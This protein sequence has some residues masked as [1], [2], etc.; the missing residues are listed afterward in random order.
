VDRHQEA[1]SAAAGEGKRRRTGFG[2]GVG[3]SGVEEG[4]RRRPGRRWRLARQ[5]ARRGRV[6]SGLRWRAWG[7]WRTTT[8]ADVWSGDGGRCGQRQTRDGRP[9]PEWQMARPVRVC[10]SPPASSSETEEESGKSKSIL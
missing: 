7:W 9:Q 1:R 10:V 3:R 6:E 5:R 4:R 2:E 8:V